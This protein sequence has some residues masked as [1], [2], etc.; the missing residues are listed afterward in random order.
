MEDNLIT[1]SGHAVSVFDGA[2]GAGSGSGLR[3]QLVDG[4]A[5]RRQPPTQV[6]IQ[7]RIP[8]RHSFATC[9]QLSYSY[10]SHIS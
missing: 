10:R 2:C 1:L 7:Y 6:E 8:H 3:R 4:C 9:V 5:R